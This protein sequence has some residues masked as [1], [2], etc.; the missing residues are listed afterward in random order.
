MEVKEH[1][2]IQIFVGRTDAS[3]NEVTCGILGV[4]NKESL[5][6]L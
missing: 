3:G 2:S 1:S 6:R 4:D 5:R